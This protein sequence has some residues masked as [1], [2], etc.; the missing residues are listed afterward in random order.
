MGQAYSDSMV[1]LVI[2]SCLDVVAV[3]RGQLHQMLEQEGAAKAVC[4]GSAAANNL[5]A[6]YWL[7]DRAFEE[8]L[9]NRVRRQLNKVIEHAGKV[10]RCASTTFYLRLGRNQNRFYRIS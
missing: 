10:E 2:S 6:T 9:F 3:R 5:Q 7:L 4:E 8:F 1:V